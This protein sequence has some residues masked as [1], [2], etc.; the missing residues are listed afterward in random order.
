MSKD[1]I[2][3]VYINYMKSDKTDTNEETGFFG[4]GSKTPLAYADSFN[5]TGLRVDNIKNLGNMYLRF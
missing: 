4:L 2:Y 3:N 5:I 1:V